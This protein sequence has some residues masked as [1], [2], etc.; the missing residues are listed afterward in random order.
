MKLLLSIFIIINIVF[1]PYK[2]AFSQGREHVK[3]LFLSVDAVR[4]IAINSNLDVKLA[5]IDSKI[6][7]TDLSYKEAVFD[8]LL[9]A[10]ISYTRDETKSASL[11]ASSKTLTNN[12]NIGID[13][14]L[15]SGTDISVDFTNKRESSNSIYVS[16]NPY[17]DSQ[18][19]IN[20]TQP[21]AKNF[22]GLIDRG[23]IEIIKWEIKNAELDSYIK[24][25]D[26]IILTEESYWK[27]VLTQ[28]DFKIK[29]AMLKKSI[30]LFNQY[31]RKLKIGLV[32]IGEV[33]AIEA[34]MHLRESELLLASNEV[35]SAEELLS[36]R[37]NMKN[38]TR[39]LAT[40]SLSRADFN[41]N[42]IK[43]LNIAFENRRDYTSKK[44]DI[45]SKN[46]NLEMKSNSLFPEIDLTATLASNGI[47]ST[48][49]GA[50]EDIF[51]D[52][53]PE[54]SIGIEFSFPLE[55]SEAKSEHEKAMLE[56]KK[57]IINLQKTERQIVS[58]IDEKFR[59]MSID[60][61]NLKKMAHI[62]NLQKRK[63]DQEEKRFKYGRSNSD[64]LIRYHEDLLNAQLMRQKAYFDYKVSILGLMDAEDTFLKHAGL[65]EP[66]NEPTTI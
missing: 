27:L 33:L 28:E 56:K 52:S 64:T 61:T 54:Y 8:A 62:E 24:I 65:E 11:F 3:T 18:I 57:A 53:N 19:G 49:H 1:A 30:R 40:D 34:N 39:L 41:T 9:K 13:K 45:E 4:L 51:T 5:Q 38:K 47:G 26:A 15:R 31:R 23:N 25:E 10:E 12:Y 35:S 50:I 22:F 63:L 48:Y 59:K 36:L 7:G 37:L 60:K 58:D 42:F 66:E 29:K 2:E 55:N 6:K 20:V 43:S 14:K 32:E 16:P 46:I 17:H 44:N 21:I